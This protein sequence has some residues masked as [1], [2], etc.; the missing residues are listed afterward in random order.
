[1][2]VE[3][4]Y[5]IRGVRI[6]VPGDPV[7]QGRPRFARWKARD[8]REGVSA[9]DPPKSRSWKATAQSH[10]RDACDG[11]LK[12]SGTAWPLLGPMSVIIR[13]VF[14]CPKSDERKRDPRPRRWHVNSRGDVENIAKAVLDA[15]TGVLYLD[16]G[17]VA[18]L[19]V[20]KVIGAQGEPSRVEVWCQPL[21]VMP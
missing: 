15:G 5:A 17:Q 21:P 3:N 18:R 6:V 12:M 14:L 20:E 11:Y 10:M 19:E 8:G 1:M 13:A 2:A 7:P 16:D 9:S 4:G